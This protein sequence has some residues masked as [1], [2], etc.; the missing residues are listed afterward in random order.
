MLSHIKKITLR[1][2]YT[3]QGNGSLPPYLGSTIRGLLGHSL[4]SI[5]CETPRVKCHACQLA[6]NCDYANYFMSPKN[7]AGSVNRMILHIK[8]ESRLN[9][10]IGDICTF[11]ITVIASKPVPLLVQMFE[12]IKNFGWGAERIPFILNKITNVETSKLVWFNSKIWFENLMPAPLEVKTESAA[13]VLLEFTA[14][15]RLEKSKKLIEQPQF[16][17][18]IHSITRRLGL[19]SHAYTGHKMEWDYE[20]MLEEARKVKLVDCHWKKDEFTRYSMNQKNEKLTMPVM[21]GWA[22]YEGNITPFTPILDAGRTIHIG[23]NSTHGF[24]AFTINYI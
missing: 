21:S 14:P 4:R 17:H 16:E 22:M 24:G 11:D 8:P 6:V 18:I 7:E 20:A 1:V 2:E 19:L 12:N 9:W 15:L 3:A 10:R 5:V 13:G 23:R